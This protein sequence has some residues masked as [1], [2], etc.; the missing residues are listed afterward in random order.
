MDPMPDRTSR[1]QDVDAAKERFRRGEV[2]LDSYLE[3]LLDAHRARRTDDVELVDA[4]IEPTIAPDEL[5]REDELEETADNISPELPAFSALR[6]A[7]ATPRPVPAPTAAPAAPTSAPAPAPA[8]ASA[9]A[10]ALTSAPAQAS[11][12]APA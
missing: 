1:Q 6:S 2:E 7:T 8:P 11:A 4:Q 12:P 9:S 5:D 3:S 10:P